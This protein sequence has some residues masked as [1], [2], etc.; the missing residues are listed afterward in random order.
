MNEL[1]LEEKSNLTD[2]FNTDFLHNMLKLISKDSIQQHQIHVGSVESW[3][4]NLYSR[5]HAVMIFNTHHSTEQ[6]EH[7]VA[8]YVDG[9]AQEAFIFDSLPVRPF[10]QNILNKLGKICKNVINVNDNRIIFQ[11]PGFPLCGIYC[12]AFLDC[13]LKHQPLN[14]CSENQLLNDV[15]VIQQMLPYMKNTINYT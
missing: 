13:C 7:W 6:G 11:H 12:L 2:V 9:T 10:P 4:I 3:P 15:S 8:V 1:T 14:L 5:Q